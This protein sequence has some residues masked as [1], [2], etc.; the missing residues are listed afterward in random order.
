MVK[1]SPKNGKIVKMNEK[2]KYELR[3]Q[4]KTAGNSR[5]PTPQVPSQVVQPSGQT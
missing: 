3:P 4:V 1:I 5:A 2:I